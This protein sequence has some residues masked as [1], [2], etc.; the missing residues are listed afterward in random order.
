MFIMK[1]SLWLWQRHW[2]FASIV[3]MLQ[4]VSLLALAQVRI[5]GKVTGE[6]GEPLPSIAVQV[7]NTVN[8]A[9][10]DIKGEYVINANLKDGSYI[11]VFTGLGLKPQERTF[12]VG[13]TKTFT[14]DVQLAEDILGLNEVIVTGTSVATSKKQLGNAVSTVSAKDI[15]YSAATG[16]D[17][18]LQGKVAG[19][20]I[21]QNS[22]NPA[23][24]ISVRLRGPSTIVGSSDPL[25]I[26]DGVIVNNDSRQLIDLGGYAQNRLVDINPADIERIEV[27]KGA[28]AAAIYGSRAN[29]GVVQIFT[30]R[31]K[32]GKPQI[33]FS[34]Q[35]KTNSLRKKL[36]YNEYPFR[37]NNNDVNDL[38]Q[39]A[40]TRYDYQD[41]IFS[42]GI[43]TDNS[44]SVSGGTEETKYYVGISSLYNE[45]I[46]ENTNF[47]RNG[48]RVNVSQKLN[49]IFT[50]SAGVN[51][52]MSSSREIPNGGIQE[53]YGALTGFIFSNNYVN[54]D[55][56]PVTGVYPSTAPIAILR[57]TNPLEAIERFDFRQKV[58]RFMG[59]VQ[60]NAKPVDGLNIDYIIGLDNYTQTATGY[61]PP[62]NTT[63][64]YNGGLSRRADATVLQM[65]NDLNISYRRKLNSWLES[66][67]G[68]GGT[69]QYD[70]AYTFGATAQQ[71]GSFGQ[72]INNGVTLAT[73]LRTERSIMGAF[74]Q[75]TFAIS[76][77][78][79]VTG[80][81]RVDASSVYGK[82]NRWQYF[83]KVSG[84]YILSEEDFWKN[85][86]LADAMPSFKLRAA[87]G[88][89]GNLTAIPVYGRFTVY[90]PVIYD[91]T[92]GYA[93]N[94][95]LGNFNVVPERQRELELGA[96]ISFLKDRISLEFTYYNKDV[97]DLILER[98][99]A[100]STAFVRRF[101][102]I[103]TMTNKGFEFMLKGVPVQTK[104]LTW[105][106]TVSYVN[107]K[108]VI[109]GVEG[110]G[111][112]PFQ[113]GFGQVAAV[114]GYPLGAFYSTFF[115][116]NDD[117]SL[118]LDAR[119]LPQRERGVQ[120]PNGTYTAQ[121]DANGQPSGAILSK[122]IG[123]PNPKH[124]I[125]W[126]NE[127]N[128]KKF[129]F[130]MQWDGML[131]FDVFNF[132]RRVGDN[133]NYGGLQG[134]EAEL[135]GDVIKGTSGAL[136]SIF[137]NWIEKGD[138]VK[139]RELSASYLITPKAGKLRDIRLTLSGRNLLSIDNYSGYDP[140]V[141]T[142]GQDNAVRGFDFVEVPLP[143][144]FQLGVNVNF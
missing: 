32:T 6:D 105:I 61:I 114:N 90:D 14:F 64:S 94:P 70:R 97:D 22:G 11:L 108:N 46:I 69:I 98:T 84:S 101:I 20:Q 78:L 83:P 3:F 26:V 119:G 19:A 121:R 128:Y 16:I 135:K 15:Q 123:D 107:N 71:L 111:V 96:D 127:F 65:N 72:T 9:Y 36:P 143:R 51:Y 18:A 137:E 54:P 80:A 117:G 134:Y 120:G 82:E 63:P 52:T 118:L 130:R 141:N 43:G 24:G 57:R 31:G 92:A 112:L 131:G 4:L 140:E 12:Q 40:V 25:Y 116:R 136:F 35:F 39:T 10:T 30:K 67:T 95:S 5:S 115:A 124:V 7:R 47:S 102:N 66:T 41:K 87:W 45:G 138:F 38:S 100:P 139:L 126:I 81:A 125:S 37:F 29:N 50:L 53:A 77:K 142:A 129:S 13:N 88:Q 55:K 2:K 1:K 86:G 75:Q 79:Y 44:L 132:T 59:N 56:D 85:S 42:T 133:Q 99:L 68:L 23:G 122:V 34:T 17:G 106:S 73:E 89:S 8:G 91:G 62:K 48:L 109:N 76:D 49:K 27:I 28:A 33:S 60:L 113:G 110:N 93:P 74:L 58:N 104:D 103:G 144:T 21:T